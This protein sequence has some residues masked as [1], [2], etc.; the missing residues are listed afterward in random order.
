MGGVRAHP[1]G[2]WKLR[3]SVDYKR[4]EIELLTL[5]AYQSLNRF[6]Y[7]VN[8]VTATI[9]QCFCATC[10]LLQ[11]LMPNTH[12]NVW[13]ICVDWTLRFQS[14]SSIPSPFDRWR[15]WSPIQLNR[16]YWQLDALKIES[17]P[18]RVCANPNPR[19]RTTH[20]AWQ[21]IQCSPAALRISHMCALFSRFC[22][23]TPK[24]ERQQNKIIRELV[25][26]M[27]YAA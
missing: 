11:A 13:H 14:R 21:S 27:V 19:G 7:Y 18:F 9:F 8:I 6:M 1:G 2:H 16:V 17:V 22:L 12:L 3:V 5:C 15:I 20:I 4:I 10:T 24:T 26:F 23:P 25:W